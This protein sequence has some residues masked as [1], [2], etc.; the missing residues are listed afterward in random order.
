MRKSSTGAQFVILVLAASIPA[1]NYYSRKGVT[2]MGVLSIVAYRPLPGKDQQLLELTK[3]H[4]PVLH[5]EGLATDR[6]SCVMR[7]KDGTIVEVFEWKSKE[8]LAAAHENSAVQEL[9]KRYQGTCE[10][11]P[12]ASLKEAH[13]IF[14][15]FEPI[16]L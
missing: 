9:W 13:D 12:L 3:Q 14:A 8:A 11:I 7:A 16:E 15:E 6:P 2:S 1:G 4:L 5:R 10:Y